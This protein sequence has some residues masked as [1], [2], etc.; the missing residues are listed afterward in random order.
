MIFKLKEK[1][2]K[3][4]F[5]LSFDLQLKVMNNRNCFN[6]IDDVI[7]YFV[8]LSVLAV[9]LFDTGEVRY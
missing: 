7:K 8:K 2:K 9:W 5:S 1:F 3:T 4:I 6:G